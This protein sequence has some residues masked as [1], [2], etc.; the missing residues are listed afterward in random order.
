VAN[1]DRFTHT[2]FNA[3]TITDEDGNAILNGS[4]EIVF[5]D[6]SHV[7][8]VG[9]YMIEKAAGIQK[10]SEYDQDG[11]AVM[12]IEIGRCNFWTTE[13]AEALERCIAADEQLLRYAR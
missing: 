6:S 8:F 5:V 1:Y 12:K 2:H 9:P 11:C 7:W 10:V 3:P 13:D 4:T